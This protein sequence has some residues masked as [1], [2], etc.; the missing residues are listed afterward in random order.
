MT[1]RSPLPLLFLLAALPAA[2]WAQVPATPSDVLPCEALRHKGDPGA[3]ACYQK[4]TRALD[5]A[6]Q[7]EGF[8]GMGDYR[9][10][11]DAFRAATKLREKDPAP[12]V[13][14]GR[15]YLDHWQAPDARDL[16]NEALML[17]ED[18][19]PALLGMALVAGEEFEGEAIRLAEKALK[20]DPKLYE[21][22]ELIA[23]VQ[24]E[25]GSAAKAAEA[26]HKALEIYPEALDAMALLGTIDLLDDKTNSPWMAKVLAINPGYGNVYAVAAHFFII[27]RRYDEGIALYRKA[28]ALD[29][30]LNGAR[31]D[32]GVNLM[33]LGQ[34][35][36]A[37]K[38][39]EQVYNAGYQNP[40]TVNSLR[41][42][43]SMKDYTRFNT[44]ATAT[45]PATV[46]VLHKKEAALLRPYFQAE[47][48]R[49][50]QTY[51]KKYHYHLTKPVQIE[52]YPNHEDFAVRTLG[53][54]GL[55]ALG[56][57]F[58][59]T[60]AMDSPSAREPG[61]WH[62]AST[63]WH[64]LS[65]VYALEMTNHRV[66]RWFTEGLAVYEETAA[67]PDWGDR[68]DPGAINAIKNKLLLPVVDMDRGFMHPT[69]PNQV[70]VS[71]FQGGKICNF[72]AEKWSYDKLIAMLHDFGANMSTAD[73]IQKEF[74][75]KPEEFDKQFLAWLEPQTAKTVAKYDDWRKRIKGVSENAKA[76][77]W[78]AV[79]EEGE[80]IRDFYPEY[81][82]KANV[83]EF[84]SDAYL[85]KGDKAKAMAQLETY[86][87][88]GG[89][90]PV[91]L[92]QL[93]EMQLEKG[94][95]KEAAA[96]LD[97]LNLIYLEDEAAHSRL[98]TIDLDL[99][100]SSGAIREFEAVLAGK[101]LDPASAHLGLAVAYKSAHRLDE[102]R[103]E[104]ISALEA[105][106][107]FK[108]AQKLLLELS[109]KE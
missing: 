48:E 64:E 97:R 47:F 14:W 12:R 1:K 31:S 92:K 52:V 30:S 5:P 15:M 74:Q 75:M 6:V 28:L 22:D 89:R 66:P 62:W 49:A 32:M 46:L 56:V 77:K 105:A 7:A 29:P 96:T 55:G 109:G 85:A 4:L 71:Y 9:S 57:T 104:V 61:Q 78:D 36:E 84:L 101:P 98:G 107:G 103:E 44:E 3:K 42:L 37:R 54:P 21:A 68:L 19:P 70:I 65:H 50:L 93:S 94:S 100:N 82:E 27:T 67:S 23:R 45:T 87:K 18:Y 24:L 90:D 102:A 83:Y 91:P 72:I 79:I 76:K 80:A 88:I 26:A 69:Y 2:V 59:Y 63:M 40:E 33:R 41:L 81:V 8:W 58:G 86:S 17:K 60:V 51:E 108:P 106:P 10:A 25:D 43:D 16:F 35:A 34:E 13:R 73:V 11:N 99:G 20:A 95:K 38:Q 39:L 53:M